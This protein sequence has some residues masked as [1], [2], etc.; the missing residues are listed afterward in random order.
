MNTAPFPQRRA[1]LRPLQAALGLACAA[2]A[3]VS[4]PT[5]AALAIGNNPL[6]LVIGKANV[7]VVL[8]NSNSMDEAAN[9]EAV[10]S[11][12]ATSKSEIAR[13]VVRDLTDKYRN[14]I[15]M[16]LMAYRQN[17]PTSGHLHNSQYDVSYNPL[18]YRAGDTGPR[19]GSV[20]RWRTANPTSAG[21]YL[22]YNVALPFYDS[23]SQGNAFCY[24]TTANA[25][26]DFKDSNGTDNYRCFRNKAGT[27]DT[28][29]AWANGS[30]EAAAGYS[31]YFGQFGLSPTDSD[32]AQGITDF[33]RFL[34]WTYVG[35]TWYRNDSP[36]RGYLHIPLGDLN[37]AKADAIKAKLVC[38]VPGVAGC[39]NSSSTTSSI[40]NAGLTPIEGTLLTARDYYKGGWSNA[41][42][43][44][45]A[46]C[47][48]LPESCKKNFVV[49]LTDGLPSTNKTGGALASP[50]TALADAA[51]AAG[52]LKTEGVET[53]V[54]GFALPTGV[55]ADTLDQIAVGGGTDKA[56]TAG[57]KAT[58]E[59]AFDAIFED[60]LK[61][62][63]SFGS[64][65]QNST[66][67]NT[68]S[69]VF[70]ASF[71]SATWSGELRALSPTGLASIWST[72]TAGRIPDAGTRKVYTRLPTGGGVEFKLLDSLATTQQG[73]LAT[74]S[75]ATGLTG[76]ACA[77]ARIDW[78]RGDRSREETAKPAGPLRARSTVLGDII[79]SSPFYVR[80]TN[81]VYV[82]AND[83]M[84]HAF[85]AAT[86][87]ELFAYIPGAVLGGMY[88][89]TNPS[90]AHEYFVD[91]DIAV[92]TPAQ[93]PGKQILVGSL[94][95][96]GKGLYALDVT[97]PTAFGATQVLWEFADADLGLVLGR[98]LIV[99]MNNGKTVV[100]VGNGP[101]SATERAFLFVI[102]VETGAL[103]RKIDTQY[104]NTT[105]ASNGLYTPNGWDLDAN[106]TIDTLYAGDLQGN[107]WKFDLSSATATS[108]GSAFTSGGK[109]APLFVATDASGNRQPITG[110]IGVGLNARKGDANF[111][112]RYV[113][114]GTGRYLTTGDVGNKAVQSWYGLID[115]GSAISG[116][117]VLKARAIETEATA[118][119][120]PVRSF[121][122]ASDGDMSGKQGWYVDLVAAAGTALGE[123]MIGEQKF[124]G[125]VL[126]ASSIVPDPNTCSPGGTGYLNAIDPFTGASLADSYFDTSG[127]GKVTTGDKVGGRVAGSIDIGVGLVGDAI[128]IG[129]KAVA[130]G[131]G[132]GMSGK[133]VESKDVEDRI[134]RGRITW[135]EVVTR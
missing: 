121:T 4:A 66:S 132:S 5:Q 57:D 75:C 45:V 1:L 23:S 123:R 47:Y 15:N 17:T 67:I 116:R 52:A 37:A 6:F 18:N 58:L 87:N 22:H 128:L 9:G 108:W 38:N 83:G 34:T 48:P 32:Y 124:F 111:A 12:S 84:L 82:A 126:T 19:S 8:D 107:L 115:A 25:S 131:T 51:A 39:N 135:R 20:K 76:T 95:R 81:T 85:D 14:R 112:K 73:A 102:D 70:Q 55:A 53:Y 106:G 98:P 33:G 72:S 13:T 88:R 65:A 46:G 86:G 43:G 125:A 42:E 41:S 96:G 3:L 60:I 31:S 62:S 101:N 74:T 68:D 127:D 10:G 93:T 24:S 28:L 30:Q 49:M 77:Q 105:T 64:V 94:G 80:K 79:G 44:Y 92:S 100:V 63:S 26:S 130:S 27:S 120:Y 54:I 119:G 29:P 118:S 61:K 104:G 103:I 110:V 40:Y 7:L 11:D 114:F 134:R 16:G 35:P 69:L 99:K 122:S 89:L 117:A 113:F 78:L 56:F 36:G 2:T 109:P 91:G 90:Y 21:N 97:D 50:A 129:G 71:N 133:T 59:A